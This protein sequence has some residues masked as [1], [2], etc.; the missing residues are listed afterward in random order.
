MP[1]TAIIFFSLK[2]GASAQVAQALKKIPEITKISSVTGDF[3]L[4]A[5]AQVDQL[6]QLHEIFVNKID[7]FDGI[8]NTTTAVVLKELL[9]KS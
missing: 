7:T 5:E 1:I 9:E 8:I 4:I 6:E 3:D 2:H